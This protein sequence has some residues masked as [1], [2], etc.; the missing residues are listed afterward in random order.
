MYERAKRL[1]RHAGGGPPPVA[2]RPPH[3]SKLQTQGCRMVC[4]AI[5]GRALRPLRPRHIWTSKT[6]A[7]EG[8]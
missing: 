8:R 2:P 4:G 6:V 1:R 5:G 7:P 3:A